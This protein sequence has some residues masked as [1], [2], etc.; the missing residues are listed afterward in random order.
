MRSPEEEFEDFIDRV[1]H[2]DHETLALQRDKLRQEWADLDRARLA[3]PAGAR[4]QALDEL[5]QHA[6]DV[7]E[8]RI[9]A[10]EHPTVLG[11]DHGREPP[12]RRR[13]R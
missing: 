8:R 1:K 9:Y 11:P 6:F 2:L 4:R 10:L 3:I 12:D 5:S 7:L 13:S